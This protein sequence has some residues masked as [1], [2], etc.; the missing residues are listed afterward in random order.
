MCS[1]PILHRRLP[2]SAP[3]LLMPTLPTVL[4]SQMRRIDLFCKLAGPLAIS[5]VD[6]I[7]TTLAIWVTL[8][9]NAAFITVE[10][11]AIAKVWPAPSCCMGVARLTD[12]IKRYT[13]WCP[14]CGCPARWQI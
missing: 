8:G 14:P 3:T 10:Y 12:P 1:A 6:S 4:N 7:S 5:L 9:I 13:T 2:W 11:F